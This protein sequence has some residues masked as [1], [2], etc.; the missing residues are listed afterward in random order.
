MITNEGT[1]GADLSEWALAMA[2]A[3]LSPDTIRL[4]VYDVRRLGRWVGGRDPWTLT[5]DEL[6][7]YVRGHRWSPETARGARSS[8]RAFWRWGVGTGRTDV[9]AAA[10]LPRIPPARPVPRPAD[11]AGVVTALR[12][13]D[14][15]LLLMLR[16]ANDL[17]MRRAEVA[18]V[19]TRDVWADLDGSSLRVHG[20]G[21]RE[22]DVPLPGD[23]ARA[24]AR[25]PAGYLF[26]GAVDGHLSARW[27]GKLVARALPGA[28]TMHGLRHLAATELFRA[29]NGDL[30]LV[31][32]LLGHASPATTARYVRVGSEQL[33]AAVSARASRWAG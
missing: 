20:K 16:L 28:D 23:L 11:P 24:I 18:Q 32:E 29:T 31:Q 12:E 2:R 1:W 7:D 27:V 15:R 10:G 22:R 8:L 26:P 21:R 14:A 17:G 5:A 9:D 3:N 33:R 25:L 19:H 6:C 4:R 13:A 30:R